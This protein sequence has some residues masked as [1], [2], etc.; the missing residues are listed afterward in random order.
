MG[1]VVASFW[2]GFFNYFL[3][4]FLFVVLGF[5]VF[6]FLNLCYLRE[7]NAVSPLW[8]RIVVWINETWHRC[9][10]VVASSKYIFNHT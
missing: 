5:L 6:L 9:L 7:I 1:F 4:G 8:D 10:L 3:S 2:G